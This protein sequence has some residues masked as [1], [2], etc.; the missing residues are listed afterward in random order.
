MAQGATPIA[1]VKMQEIS[2]SACDVDS[3][4][5]PLLID[6]AVDSVRKDTF[7]A[8]TNQALH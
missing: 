5:R 6:M 4:H 7:Q 1:D 2:R 8:G 3:A